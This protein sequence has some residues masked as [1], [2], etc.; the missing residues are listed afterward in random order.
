[1]KRRNHLRAGETIKTQKGVSFRMKNFLKSLPKHFT[2]AVKNLVRHT[3]M[4]FSSASA[5]TVTLIMM[6]CFMLLAGNISGFT[7]NVETDLKI[8]VEIDNIVTEEGI[9][10]MQQQIEAIPGVKSLTFSSK[11]AEMDILIE[12][13]GSV[14][15]RYKNNNPL[16][17]VFIV[18]TQTAKQ[19][20][21]VTKQLRSLDGVAN[22]EYG[23]EEIESMVEAFEWVRIGGGIF[24]LA[25]AFVAVFLISNTIKM[26]IYTRMTEIKI[27]RNVG[28][29]N[30]YIKMPFMFEGMLIGM[31][32]AVLPM[33]L[34]AVGY[35][36]IYQ[37][38]NGTFVSSMFVMQPPHP[39]ATWICL[40][41]LVS[42]ALV[43]ILGSL[44]AVNKYLRWNR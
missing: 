39:F 41:L 44:H 16:P 35:N 7:S 25:L 33:I 21:A 22:A 42:G 1:M 19:M 31:I 26:T 18:E 37:G 36:F 29:T 32:G 6:A 40:I 38:L 28:A 13:N 43:G 10:A 8:R 23:G 12:E 4:S 11:E 5:V 14:F 34:T 27:M 9:A 15:Q 3:A 20:K 30:W 24:L 2:T 17:N